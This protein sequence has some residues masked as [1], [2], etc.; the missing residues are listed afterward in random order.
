M[1]FREELESFLLHQSTTHEDPTRPLG[2]YAGRDGHAAQFMPSSIAKY[3]VDYDG[4]GRIDLVNNPADVIGSVANYFKS[5]GWQ[6]GIAATYPPPSA[7]VRRTHAPA[8]REGHPQGFS[9]DSFVAAGAQLDADGARHPGLLALIRCRT[10]P[11]RAQYVAGTQ[12]FYVIA[13]QLEQLL[14]DVVLDL[15]NEVKA[16]MAQ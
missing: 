7:G 2:N 3:A 1:L 13:L 15:G 4:D 6:R 8:A 14:R 9:A 11:T 16:A 5:F 12:N 10:A